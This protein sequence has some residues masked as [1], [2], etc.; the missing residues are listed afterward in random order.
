M[1]SSGPWPWSTASTPPWRSGWAPRWRAPNATP[2]STI[3]SPTR[4]TSRSTRCSIRPRTR[5]ATT[6]PRCWSSSPRNRRP[7]GSGPARRSR[8]CTRSSAPHG[9]ARRSRPV[10][11]RGPFPPGST[12]ARPRCGLRA[13]RGRPPCASRRARRRPRL[14]RP[15]RPSPCSPRC[16]RERC[17]PR[18][19]WRRDRRRTAAGSPCSP[20]VRA[21][22][23][24]SLSGAPG[25][26][27]WKIRVAARC[28]RS[29]SWRCSV[30]GGTWPV[31]APP[32]R[33]RRP[34]GPRRRA[35]S[36]ATR[37][38]IFSSSRSRS[39]RWR[40]IPGGNWTLGPRCRWRG[41]SCGVGA[42]RKAHPRG[43]ASPCW[44]R[45]ASRSSSG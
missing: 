33:V 22:C 43:S 11:G 18:C 4:S 41:W 16:P 29:P 42:A 38:A 39:P 14:G 13:P 12:G 30:A 17:S 37:T 40:T 36:T 3:P 24:R 31:R 26:C 44:T 45:S 34:R 28:C 25:S 15:R 20:Y 1:R 35:P 6:R 7:R 10:T 27:G 32:A 9:N 23:P 21:C 2:T 8:P 5:T 19:G